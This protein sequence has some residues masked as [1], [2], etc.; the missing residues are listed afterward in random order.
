MADQAVSLVFKRR[1]EAPENMESVTRRPDAFSGRAGS[2]SVPDSALSGDARMSVASQLNVMPFDVFFA[3]TVAGWV[4]TEKQLRW[5]APSTRPPLTAD[6][7]AR[8]KKPEG[9]A[10]QLVRGDDPVPV[11]YAELN[12]MHR[13]A[14]HLWLGHFVIDPVHRGLG[15]GQAFVRALLSRAFDRLLADRVSLV[16]FPDNAPALRCYLRAG[17]ALK[18]LENHQFGGT[19]P[20]HR[21]LRLEASRSVCE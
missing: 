8:W 13:E 1:S 19:G 21:L 9:L 2:D 20:R 16:V 17:F 4:R 3:R 15:I 14:G 10:F 7:V 11:G 18:R 5:L 12:P 6:K